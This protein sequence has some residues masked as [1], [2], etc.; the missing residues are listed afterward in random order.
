LFLLALD[1]TAVFIGSVTG[2]VSIRE[3][4]KEVARV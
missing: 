2:E 1:P 4:L 3:K